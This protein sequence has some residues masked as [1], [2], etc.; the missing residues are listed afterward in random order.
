MLSPKRGR[1]V[2]SAA[3]QPIPK[4]PAGGFSNFSRL[5]KVAG[6]LSQGTVLPIRDGLSAAPT[7]A[8]YAQTCVQV[9]L[10]LSTASL[11]VKAEEKDRAAETARVEARL[12]AEFPTLAPAAAAPAA[13]PAGIP[14]IRPH[15]TS[16]MPGPAPHFQAAFSDDEE[17]VPNEEGPSGA[18]G[19]SGEGLPSG[20][21][22][23]DKRQPARAQG[24]W[25]GIS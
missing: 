18:L 2:R 25:K 12:A 8:L 23:V 1:K 7:K 4:R 11:A 20:A 9:P 14:V 10:Q 19:G 16:A 22:T 17:P 15:H 24:V 21:V 5:V 6:I 3:A 13:L